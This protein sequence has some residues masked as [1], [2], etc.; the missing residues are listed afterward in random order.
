M[1]AGLARP[2]NGR[3]AR[4][5]DAAARAPVRPGASGVKG[6]NYRQTINDNKLVV[7]M[8]E[9][10]HRVANAYD[11]ASVPGDDTLKAGKIFGQANAMYASGH[12]LSKDSKFFQNGPSNDGWRPSG[13]SNPSAPPPE[14]K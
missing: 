14:E 7:V 8:I 13:V 9:T 11:I 3:S 4:R 10:P 1:R 2:S 6:V 5:P 12:P